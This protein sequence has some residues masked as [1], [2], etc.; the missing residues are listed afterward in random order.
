MSN[1]ES[2]PDGSNVKNK[3]EQDPEQVLMSTR[4]NVSY[5]GSQQPG[6]INLRDHLATAVSFLLVSVLVVL[7]QVPHLHAAF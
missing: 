5:L 7:H 1:L 2:S 6:Q 4:G 3:P